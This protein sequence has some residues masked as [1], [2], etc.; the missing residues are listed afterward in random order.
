MNDNENLVLDEGTENVEAT[1][2]EEMVEQVIEPEK[3]YTEEEFN[4]KLN[5]V[6][7]KR[8]AR[9][10]AK[11]RKEYERKYGGLIDVLKAGTG[12][13]DVE[14]LTN[15]FKEHYSKRG[16]QFAEKPTYSD[17]DIKVLAKAEADD[18]IKSGFEE[19]V[20]EADRLNE[21][22]AENMTAREKALFVALTDHINKTET[23]R[24]LSK[25]GVSEDVYGSQEF[26]DFA[27]KFNSNTPITEIYKIYNQT[28]PKKEIKPM[29]SIKNT[30]VDNG[31]K[32]FY[33]KEEVMKFTKE[34]FDK[35]P[36]LFKKCEE[37]MQKWK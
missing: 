1:T 32:D 3:V 30:T 20:E 10:E 28:K 19:V 2:T 14:E 36:A 15:T 6:S 9:K 7:G 12:I 11:V 31:V 24:E 17:S 34:D 27:S 23:S 13:N 16:V 26:K 25:I 21:L 29:G 37:S 35:N 33:T 18:I 4:N 22:G 5:D 8:A